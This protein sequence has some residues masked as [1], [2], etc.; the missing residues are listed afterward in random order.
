MKPGE[1]HQYQSPQTVLV[2]LLMAT[3]ATLKSRLFF[4]SDDDATSDLDC[5][6]S[7]LH[8]KSGV[9]KGQRGNNNL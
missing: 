1:A 4:F 8:E 7:R 5:L 6:T 2:S 3:A 9:T